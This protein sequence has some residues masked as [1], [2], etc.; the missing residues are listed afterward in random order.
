MRIRR[1]LVTVVLAGAGGGFHTVPA[2][3]APPGLDGSYGSGGLVQLAPPLPAGLHPA[4]GFDGLSD[5]R[6][7]T[8]STCG[9]MLYLT[10]MIEASPSR[11]AGRK[12]GRA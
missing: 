4:E 3:A 10:Q 5:I 11:L 1:S 7:C 9:D 6:R 8:G 12:G 2:G